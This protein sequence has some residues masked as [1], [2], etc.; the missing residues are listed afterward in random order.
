MVA[1]LPMGS[2]SV[3][4]P[5]N[6]AAKGKMHQSTGQQQKHEKMAPE[7]SELNFASSATTVTS[8]DKKNVS[9]LQSYLEKCISQEKTPY[10]A[11]QAPAKAHAAFLNGDDSPRIHKGELFSEGEFSQTFA[12]SKIEGQ[13]TSEKYSIKC[14]HPKVDEQPSVH[15]FESAVSKLVLEAL[16]LAS[17]EH[18]FILKLHGFSLGEHF[19]SVF[20]L[21]AGI[22]ETL[23][24][25]MKSWK[26][27]KQ[28]REAAKTERKMIL[29]TLEMD[30]LVKD[31]SYHNKNQEGEPPDDTL[32]IVTNYALQIAKA[33]E[34]LHER[35]I[36]V[37]DLRPDIIAF[38]A[39]P[40]HHTIQ[41]FD[42]SSC[43]E[44]PTDGSLLPPE[45][46][47]KSNLLKAQSTHSLASLYSACDSSTS[48]D[49]DNIDLSRHTT[50]SSK[51]WDSRG[52]GGSMHGIRRSN[53]HRSNSFRSLPNLSRHGKRKLPDEKPAP[54]KHYRAP[55]TYAV[56]DP[57][58]EESTAATSTR[59][60][61]YEG[62]STKADMFTW[63]MIFFEMLTESRPYSHK[64][65]S[66]EAHYYRVQTLGK[67]PNLNKHHFP[68]T[69][70]VVLEQAW[71]P[72]ISKRSSA[73][74]VCKHMNVILNMLEGKGVP[75]SSNSVSMATNGGNREGFTDTGFPSIIGLSI[76]DSATNGR[77]VQQSM[78]LPD[79]AAF[80]MLNPS[81]STKGWSDVWNAKTETE[82]LDAK[83]VVDAL[84]AQ[85]GKVEKQKKKDKNEKASWLRKVASLRKLIP[86]VPKAGMVKNE[87]NIAAA[88]R[89]LGPD[90]K[91]H[92]K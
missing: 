50:K 58:I 38:K 37:R 27:R 42:L 1:P 41:L 21:S 63:S 59:K 20:L 75:W 8:D 91:K 89:L 90:Y 72:L 76:E 30:V 19:D 64:V 26:R 70:K 49:K 5:T 7:T 87:S 14:L 62:Y 85:K 3:S 92:M 40:E 71:H 53:N 73:A 60:Y 48:T 68:R 43:R 2:P 56:V 17:L 55:E 77:S 23:E 84:I 51:D 67:R 74:E 9:L 52:L 12:V 54:H 31:P 25:R 11:Q 47:T 4:I 69:I 33:L 82:K 16:Y 61:S 35:G 28:E 39:F 13:T 34:Y 29:E 65:M 88:K 81:P 83:K 80:H 6:E 86:I 57:T 78:S 45:E 24:R 66:K 15:A 79:R 10:L 22:S 36:V 44:V 18:D 46:V 32:V